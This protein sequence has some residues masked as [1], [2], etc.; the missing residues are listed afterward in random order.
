MVTEMRH[1]LLIYDRRAGKITRH[2]R[3]LNPGDALTARFEA[4][5]EHQNNPDIEVVV[6]S[7]ESWTT[8]QRTHSRYF[9]NEQKIAESVLEHQT[10]PIP[11]DY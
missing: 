5:R 8:V 10:P 3:Y 11:K 1:Y 9:K 6:L 7:A 4:E 2:R